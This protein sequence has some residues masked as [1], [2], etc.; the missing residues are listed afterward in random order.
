MSAPSV[1]A[2][3]VQLVNRSLDIAWPRDVPFDEVAV[4]AIRQ[5]EQLRQAGYGRWMQAP[6]EERRKPRHL[7]QR[8]GK[9]LGNGLEAGRLDLERRLHDAD[10]VAPQ[11]L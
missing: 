1:P 10:P 3:L 9:P 7:R 8:V 4:A 5:P 6:W 11:T 2:P